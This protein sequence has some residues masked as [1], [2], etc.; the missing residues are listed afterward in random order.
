MKKISIFALAVFFVPTVVSAFTIVSNEMT[1][2][3][4]NP[5]VALSFIHYA[6]TADLDG[7][8]DPL[9]NDGTSDSSKWIWIN[10][11]LPTSSCDQTYLFE[12][13]FTLSNPIASS[14]L[15]FAVDNRAVVRLNG[16]IIADSQTGMA[17]SKETEGVYIVP[18]EDFIMGEN[19]LS[20]TATNDGCYIDQPSNPAGI[21][22]KLVMEEEVATPVITLTNPTATEDDGHIDGK[23]V[24]DKTK[25]TFSVTAT[26]DPEVKLFVDGTATILPRTALGDYVTT[27]TF[28]KGTHNWYFEA[29]KNGLATTTTAVKTFTTG[30]SNV[31]FLPGIKA[32]R[33]FKQGTLF[34]NQLWEPN[35]WTDTQDISLKTNG[36][37]VD[38]K[39]YTKID[40]NLGMID[41]ANLLPF[42]DVLQENYYVSFIDSMNKMVSDGNIA[43]WKALPYDWRLAFPDILA[44]GKIIGDKIYYDSSYATDTPYILQELKSLAES[45]DTGK[46]TIIAHSMGGLLAKK[47]LHGQSNISEI[48]DTLILVDSPQ[49]G[50]AQ[51]VATLL[52]GTGEDIPLNNFGL[53]TDAQTGRRVAQ[54]M[55]SAYT[56][57]PS[58]EYMTRVKDG[59]NNFT[60]V[61]SLDS[62]LQKITGDSL[63]NPTTVLNYYQQNY[64][65]TKII[66]HNALKDFLVGKD[67]HTTAPDNDIIH[68][69]TIQEKMMIDAEN[70][71]NEIDNW[72]PPEKMRVVQIAGWGIP[73]TIRGIT[74]KAKHVSPLCL[75]GVSCPTEI[76]DTV[77]EFTFD[78]DGTVVVPS[79][80][81]MNTETYFVDLNEHNSSLW[82]GL[83]KNRSHGSVLEVDN[84]RVLISRIIE[85]IS[86][87]AQGLAYIKTDKNQL[88]QGELKDL[89]RLSLHSPVK[90]DVTNQGGAHLGISTNSTETRTLYDTQMPNSYYLEMGEGKYLGFP[91]E[92]ETTIKLQ[93]TGTGT[94]T[95]N[96]EQYQGDTQEGTQT[97][98]DIPVSPTTKATLIINTL[99]DAKELAI[100]QNGDGTIDSIVFT[101]ENK[102]TVTFQT[103]KTQIQVLITKTKPVLLIE[104][105]VAEKQ[106]NKKNYQATKALL[107]VLKKE[108]EVLS[109]QKIANKWQIEKIEALRLF[110]TLNA[111]IEKVNMNIP[112][113]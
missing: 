5:A 108:I 109:K 84:L 34:E 7:L 37:S 47:I 24:A 98:T 32:S 36:A 88:Q 8:H 97:F 15:Y 107:L 95:L 52:H 91:I 63:F 18:P 111:L 96:L 101:D 38:N 25:F 22:Y 106:F 56:L 112:K 100:D 67:G 46:V 54:N 57:L 77:P 93:G 79:Q 26:G 82:S 94:F 105:V 92:T 66:T 35:W 53:F 86:N 45:S 4:G 102:E 110:A 49:F 10:D 16:N 31:A 23:G 76:F 1:T 12:K 50:T 51:A 75:P 28:P 21:L 80:I 33:L 20:I 72:V 99:S 59:M 71:H 29:N 48:T 42:P 11:D 90:V 19:K 9:K 2:V 58:L 6:W 3:G 113:K 78:G 55:A 68:P 39:I 17:Y 43:K 89:I 62:S 64:R 70:I 13:T 27:G 40:A 74:Y 65:G 60:A 14:T 44:N 103:L 69:M 61:I 85:N 87:P 30:Y 81:A 104:V 83:K 73:E 41:Q